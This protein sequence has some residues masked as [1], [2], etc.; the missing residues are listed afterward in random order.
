MIWQ[1]AP[2]PLYRGRYRV[3]SAG[4]VFRLVDGEDVADFI[5]FFKFLYDLIAVVEISNGDSGN[6]G[7][8]FDR[9]VQIF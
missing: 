4:A 7:K 1:C 5:V 3:L 8:G 6:I 9:A 2:T